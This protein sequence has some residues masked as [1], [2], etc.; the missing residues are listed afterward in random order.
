MNA[1]RKKSGARTVPASKAAPARP[2]VRS[3]SKSSSAKK[4]ARASS[5]AKRSAKARATLLGADCTIEHAP[6][7]H[8]QLAQVLA[9]RACVTLDFSAVKRCDTAG[10]QLLAAF[11]RERREAG[12]DVA[13]TGAS[14]N[15]HATANVLG[16]AALFDVKGD[17][18]PSAIPGA[19]LA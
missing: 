9:H 16:L 4:T 11:I 15:F 19:G 6:A 12:L 18:V 14:D 3:A 8:A 2:S 17:A 1:R 7:L 10:L 13:L 5:Q